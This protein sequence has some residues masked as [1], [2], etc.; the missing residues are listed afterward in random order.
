MYLFVI[1][2]ETAKD[3]NSVLYSF[4]LR[5]TIISYVQPLSLM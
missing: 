1:G 4:N 2:I 3:Q 5:A